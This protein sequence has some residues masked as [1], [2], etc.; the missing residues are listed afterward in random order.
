M[1][2]SK[3]ANYFLC[4]VRRLDIKKPVKISLKDAVAKND[5]DLHNS[6]V[7]NLAAAI[8][9]IDIE[10]ARLAALRKEIETFANNPSNLQNTSEVSRLYK[11]ASYVSKDRW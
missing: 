2:L 7:T 11:E 8:N 1:T 9:K 5:A 4:V 6:N 3:G 10:I